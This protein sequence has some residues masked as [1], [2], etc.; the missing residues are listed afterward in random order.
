MDGSSGKMPISPTSAAVFGIYSPRSRFAP[1]PLLD[2]SRQY[3][4]LRDTIRAAI[5]RVCDSGR[6]VLGPDCEQFEQAVA[7]YTGLN[8]PSAAP[9][10]AMRC[11]WH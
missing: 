8:M 4:P 7:A 9:R 6:F 1:V 3:E 2:M 10:A 11:C 5:D